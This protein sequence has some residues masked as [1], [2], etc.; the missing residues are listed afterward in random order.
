MRTWFQNL[1]KDE[2]VKK[3]FY[4]RGS[5][6]QDD[7]PYSLLEYEL[8]SGPAL[9]FKVKINPYNK[10]GLSLGL[11]F[12]T[13][14]LK[15]PFFSFKRWIDGSRETGFYLYDWAIVWGLMDHEWGNNHLRTDP[16]WRHFYFHIDDFFLGKSA[17]LERE[18]LSNE[19]IYF[20]LDDKEFVM[21][22]IKWE[23]NQS[24]RKHI[25]F[26]IY[27]RDWYSVNMKIDK[28][29]MVSGKGESDYDCGDDGSFGMSAG[30]KFPV[31][32][33]WLTRD[34][35]TK[36][37]VDYYVESVLSDAKRYGGSSGER[38]VN[39][40]SVYQY[41]GRKKV[42]DGLCEAEVK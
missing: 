9:R 32:P 13:A 26:S 12:F 14:Y 30:W 1:N 23:L 21:D 6:S 34:E 4:F 37:A 29:P 41:I 10:L 38:G 2:K 33:G 36:L 17:R 40:N 27:H 16:W 19:S 3:L 42:N 18:V 11:G 22:S 15:F 20:K 24:F 25:P 35:C 39:K 5:I 7:K 31:K 28:P 8:S